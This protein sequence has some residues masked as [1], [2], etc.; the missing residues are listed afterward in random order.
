MMQVA[1][2]SGEVFLFHGV[3]DV[4]VATL[5]RRA[6]GDR[7]MNVFATSTEFQLGDGNEATIRNALFES[8]AMV[9]LLTRSTLHSEYVAFEVGAAM[10]LEKPIFV[11][12]DG[13]PS[14]EI[15]GFLRKYPTIPLSN[16]PDLVK[17]VHDINC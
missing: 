8:C 5:V 7:G 14:S 6:F 11:V 17:Q 13:I 15:P 9:V 2:P 4:G 1:A 16:L 12:Y 10:G 3:H